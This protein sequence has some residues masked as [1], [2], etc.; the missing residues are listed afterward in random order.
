MSVNDQGMPTFELTYWFERGLRGSRPAEGAFRKRSRKAFVSGP[1]INPRTA[2][3]SGLGVRASRAS[4]RLRDGPG[5]G[6]RGLLQHGRSGSRQGRSQLPVAI[7]RHE[8]FHTRPRG[9]LEGTRPAG[10]VGS[11]GLTSRFEPRGTRASG[12]RRSR[13]HGEELRRA[14]D[15]DPHE[16][17]TLGDDGPRTRTDTLEE[18]R[19]TIP[20]TGG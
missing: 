16:S 4:G 2:V 6:G 19:G 9:P 11:C 8:I 5:H 3:P 13:N 20:S 12:L 7:G 15:E 14:N 17:A 10:S 18:I 1:W